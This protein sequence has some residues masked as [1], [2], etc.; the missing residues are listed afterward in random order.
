MKYFIEN[1][2]DKKGRARTDDRYPNRIGS[3]AKF[4]QM[5]KV[6]QN[7]YFHYVKYKNEECVEDHI[8][9]TSLVTDV[10]KD[11]TPGYLIVH[12]LNSIYYFKEMEE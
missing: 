10:D 3:I 11:S 7:F 4:D 5:P 8:T 9:R 6:Y 2:T 1:I 12:T